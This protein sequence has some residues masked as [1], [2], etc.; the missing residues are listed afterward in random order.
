MASILAPPPSTP[1]QNS[2]A[3][4][5]N[6]PHSRA[7]SQVDDDVM[8]VEPVPPGSTSQ[9]PPESTNT[10]GDNSMQVDEPGANATAPTEPALRRTPRNIKPVDR[11]RDMQLVVPVPPSRKPKGKQPKKVPPTVKSAT[12]H[13]R[14][15]VIGSKYMKFRFIDLTQVEV[16]TISLLYFGALHSSSPSSAHLPPWS[17]PEFPW[18]IPS[19]F[20]QVPF[21]SLLFF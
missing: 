21:D 5:G 20:H 1:P 13:P 6:P 10:R 16:G 18:Y 14:P 2:T 19:P 8:Q 9:A 7:S 11:T 12:P 15:L 17:S 4:D 3:P